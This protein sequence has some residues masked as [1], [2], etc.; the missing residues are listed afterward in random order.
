MLHKEDSQFTVLR[1]SI[2]GK[3]TGPTQNANHMRMQGLPLWLCGG[4]LITT[5]IPFGQSSDNQTGL[6]RL[7]LNYS[8]GNF[9]GMALGT[10]GGEEGKQVS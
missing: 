1:I 9:H 6:I 10:R 5:R 8:R 7:D 2:G 3:K 4:S